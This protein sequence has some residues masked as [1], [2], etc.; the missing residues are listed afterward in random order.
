MAEVNCPLGLLDIDAAAD[1][2]DGTDDGDDDEG[3]DMRLVL[4]AVVFCSR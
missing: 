4:A 2:E 3:A 1:D